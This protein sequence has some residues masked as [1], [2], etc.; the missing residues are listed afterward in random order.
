MTHLLVNHPDFEKIRENFEKQPFE[1]IWSNIV[2]Y[3]GSEFYSE[4]GRAFTYW[5]ND[6]DYVFTSQ[7]RAHFHKDVIEKCYSVTPVKESY[8]FFDVCDSRKG[9]AYIWG[10]LHDVRILLKST[11][12]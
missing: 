2:T 12:S 11:D 6:E 8:T 10:L 9:S 5:I 7:T 1:N 4:T 3:Q